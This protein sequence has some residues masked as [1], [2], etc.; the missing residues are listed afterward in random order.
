MVICFRLVVVDKLAHLQLA[1]HAAGLSGQIG[2]LAHCAHNR[3]P[4]T[5]YTQ[6][7]HNGLRFMLPA[8]A[9]RS[10]SL[11][12]AH[13]TGS[14]LH[15]T[16]RQHTMACASCCQPYR[17]DRT[18]CT[19][20]TQQAAVYTQTPH[21]GLRFMLPALA[22]RSDSLHTAHATGSRLHSTHRQHTMACASCCR[23]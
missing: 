17:S 5:L 11:H 8:L 2:Q 10:D 6:T 20:R 4:S 22:V 21:N 1:L 18:A 12:T 13:A 9:V 19:L 16:H 7:T 15:S 14:R 23:P 3:E